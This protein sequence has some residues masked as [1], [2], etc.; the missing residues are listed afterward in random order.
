MAC[1]GPGR[2]SSK[3]PPGPLP[4]TDLDDPSATPSDGAVA[5]EVHEWGLVRGSWSDHTVLSGP[6]AAPV[7]MPVAKPVL[8]F[9]R[10]GPG[11]LRVRVGVEIHGGRIVEFWP[12]TDSFRAG[13]ANLAWG[14][15]D[16][17][18]EGCRGLGYPNAA[19]QPCVGLTDSVGCEAAE[20]GVVETDDA[21]CLTFLGRTYNHLF[22]RGEIDEPAPFP[23]VA[24]SDASQPAGT[25]SLSLRDGAPM[26]GDVVRVSRTAATAGAIAVTVVA[27][28]RP[29]ATVVM[30]QPSPTPDA[31]ARGAGALA[32][33]LAQAGLSASEVVAFRRAWDETLFGTAYADAGGA[34]SAG[35]VATRNPSGNPVTTIAVAE[36][37]PQGDSDALLYVLPSRDADALASLRFDPP[38][39]AVRRAIVVWLDLATG[40]PARP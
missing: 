13:S 34:S 12:L 23:L 6:R 8:Y 21:V 22:Y 32:R 9:H 5:Y 17:G 18:S 33:S 16:V 37:S 30:A 36:A 40:N 14:P 26:V 39:R 15:V 20:L 35:T 27:A 24:A 11:P 25:L 28:P 31:A 1:S 19:E 3:S 4:T 38:P 2:G 10:L 29:G 7:P